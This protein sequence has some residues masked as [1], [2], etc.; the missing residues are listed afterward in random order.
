M[1]RLTKAWIDGVKDIKIKR[2]NKLP[3]DAIYPNDKSSE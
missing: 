2:F 3:E 1:N